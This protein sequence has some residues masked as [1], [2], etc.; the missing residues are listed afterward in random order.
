M[1]RVE[2]GPRRMWRVALGARGSPLLDGWWC[3]TRKHRSQSQ[4]VHV[5]NIYA[6]QLTNQTTPM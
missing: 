6:D 5:W 3:S 2:R 4:T 1:W